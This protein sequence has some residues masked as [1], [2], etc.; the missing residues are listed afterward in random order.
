[1]H[2]ETSF[3]E[4]DVH[5]LLPIITFDLIVSEDISTEQLQLFFIDFLDEVLQEISDTYRFDFS[6][7]DSNGIISTFDQTQSPDMKYRVRVDGHLYYFYEAPTQESLI[8]S[9]NVYFSFWGASDLQERLANIGLDEALIVSISI[10]GEDVSFVSNVS[11]V[12][13]QEVEIEDNASQNI[14]LDD[15]GHLSKSTVVML[16]TGFVIA[17]ATISLLIFRH[18]IGRKRRKRDIQSQSYEIRSSK[19]SN[20]GGNGEKSNSSNVPKILP[21]KMRGVKK[22]STSCDTFAS[23]KQVL[24]E[25]KKMSND[26]KNAEDLSQPLASQILPKYL[27]GKEVKK[28]LGDQKTC[29]EKQIQDENVSGHLD[30]SKIRRGKHGQRDEML[31]E[32]ERKSNDSILGQETNSSKDEISEKMLNTVPNHLSQN[33]K[34]IVDQPIS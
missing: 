17:V 7:L 25:S 14:L 24:S 6:H 8:Q 31:V 26:F 21:H 32:T 9:L 16:Y 27:F 34:Q 11:E 33:S 19:K 10:G 22:S 5:M 30:D 28:K 3:E 23:E 18:Y 2:F 1:M 13:G 20:N 4:E 29:R 15:G 12:E